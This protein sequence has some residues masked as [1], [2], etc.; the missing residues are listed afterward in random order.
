MRRGKLPGGMSAVAHA[1]LDAE[2]DR[3][4]D[5]AA[6]GAA[7]KDI[8][9]RRAGIER[10]A[11]RAPVVTHQ[12]Q[13]V[14]VEVLSP[15]VSTVISARRPSDSRRMPSSA[16]FV[17]PSSS[18]SC[19]CLIRIVGNEGFGILRLEEGTIGKNGISTCPAKAVEGDRC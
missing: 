18:R 11:H 5:R 12:F 4:H 14:S 13:H 16:R 10:D 19:V 3:H 15:A 6:H 7:A 2:P 8:T 1:V 17:S 9:L